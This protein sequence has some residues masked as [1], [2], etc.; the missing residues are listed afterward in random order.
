MAAQLK[1]KIRLHKNTKFFGLIKIYRTY[2]VE[3]KPITLQ[4]HKYATSFL[5]F[6]KNYMLLASIFYIFDLLKA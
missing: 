3:P 2:Y 6:K 1:K 4:K 5:F